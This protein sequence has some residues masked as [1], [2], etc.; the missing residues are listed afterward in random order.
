MQ[1]TG[2]TSLGRVRLRT[3]VYIRWIAVLGQIFTLLIV[4]FGLGFKLPLVPALIVIGASI[5]LNVFLVS[6]QPLRQFLPDRAAAIFLAYDVVQ[7]SA[8]LY[9]SGGLQN[10]FAVLLL[11]PVTVSATVLSRDNTI[12]LGVLA[13][14]CVSV[15]AF[16]H[17]PLP[18]KDGSLALDDLH[19]MGIWQAIALATVFIAAYVGSVAGEARE[20]NEALTATQMALSREQQLAEVGALTAA[21][22][23]EL[24]SP[25]AT[26]TVIAHEMAQDVDPDTPLGEDV[27]LLVEQT[28]R[29]RH[30]LAELGR[31]HDTSAG[32]AYTHLPIS[33]MVSEAARPHNARGIK[34]IDDAAPAPEARGGE[35]PEVRRTPEFMHGVGT[36]IQNAIQFARNEVILRTR[37]S[38]EHVVVEIMD[39]GPGFSPHLLD[40]LG[41]PY[42][43]TRA[44]GKGEG[45]HMGLGIFIA[46]NLLNRTGAVLAFENQDWWDWWGA[47]AIVRITW[48]RSALE[49][50][51]PE[52]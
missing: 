19:I 37:W 7:L 5:G 14:A 34:L 52:G 27:T 21:A 50:D 39:D 35:E 40:R 8:L 13:L 2:G 32:E 24:G 26:I 17:E 25:L 15:L 46:Q 45:E 9:L 42:V 36:L 23:H 30:I 49:S 1:P 20:L 28:T 48:P 3:L 43:S 31:K 18:W 6:T 22:A 51:H 47:G 29:C 33:T 16:L 44:E 38:E 4:H 12:G 11:A 10:P 41:E